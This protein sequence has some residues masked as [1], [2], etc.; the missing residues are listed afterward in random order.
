MRKV[1][2]LLILLFVI[3]SSSKVYAKDEAL[4]W[5]KVTFENAG[6]ISIPKSWVV[7]YKDKPAVKEGDVYFQHCMYAFARD[8]I[9]DVTSTP[10]VQV[11]AWWP[12]DNQMTLQEAL[13]A[14]SSIILG[15][16]KES[17]K[18]IRFENFRNDTA[19]SVTYEIN[20]L[21]SIAVHQKLLC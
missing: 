18:I 6:T 16:V 1:Y 7:V 11:L 13:L 3:V 12:I 10:I 20:V 4:Q 14:S 17:G 15:E 19:P 5:Q 9:I 2:F 8:E 21:S